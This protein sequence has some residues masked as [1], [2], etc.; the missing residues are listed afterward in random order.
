MKATVIFVAGV[1][2]TAAGVL[3]TLQGA[4]IIRWPAESFMVG[5]VDWIEYG[6]VITMIGI[7]L[8]VAARR[9]RRGSP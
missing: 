9:V 1:L 2:V 3:F 5:T 8:M 4:N 7:G 6:I